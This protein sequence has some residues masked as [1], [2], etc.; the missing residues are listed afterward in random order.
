MEMVTLSKRQEAELREEDLKMLRFSVG[1]TRMDRMRNEHI[2]GTVQVGRRDQTGMGW[3][4]VE[5]EE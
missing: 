3:T 2:R 4:Y 5:E 1:E